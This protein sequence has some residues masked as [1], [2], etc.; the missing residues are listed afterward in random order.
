MGLQDTRK[1][2]VAT[3]NAER[4]RDTGTR[5]GQVAMEYLATYGWAVFALFIVIAVLIGTGMFNPGRF[6]SDECILQPNM[7][8]NGYYMYYDDT[9]RELV[10]GFELGNSMGSTVYWRNATIVVPDRNGYANATVE[11]E[12]PAKPGAWT[13][14]G[15]KVNVTIPILNFEKPSANAPKKARLTIS[16]SVCEGYATPAE[17]Y[18]NA[19]VYYTSGRLDAVVRSKS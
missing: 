14:Q 1:G 10:S 3:V 2:Q 5:R 13:R 16:F 12:N 15:E 7:P 8:C 17:C 18:N 11:I 9:N 4:W 6:T 19:P